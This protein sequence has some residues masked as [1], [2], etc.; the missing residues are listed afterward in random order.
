MAA[1]HPEA[2]IQLILAKG[3]ANDPKRTLRLCLIARL[4]IFLQCFAQLQQR[5]NEIER[6]RENN[7]VGCLSADFLQR[8][9]SVF[10]QTG[11]MFGLAKRVF[12]SS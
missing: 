8:L 4:L 10:K 5:R 1:L 9:L 11:Q 2:D 12:C 6:Q 3:S 7:R